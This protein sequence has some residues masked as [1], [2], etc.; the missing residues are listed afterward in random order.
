MPT[1]KSWRPKME[2][3]KCEFCPYKTPHADHLSRHIREVFSS[4]VS[5]LNLYLSVAICRNCWT[6]RKMYHFISLCVLIFIF[7]VVKMGFKWGMAVLLIWA[8]IIKLKLMKRKSRSEIGLLNTLQC[9][10]RGRQELQVRPLRLRDP[11][12]GAAGGPQV[13]LTFYSTWVRFFDLSQ[14]NLSLTQVFLSQFESCHVVVNGSEKMS[15]PYSQG[16]A[17]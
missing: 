13:R 14:V 5:H 12:E 4:P 6:L 16:E 10:A 1:A 3:V 7:E 8:P 15:Q 11:R 2:L 17:P 9:C